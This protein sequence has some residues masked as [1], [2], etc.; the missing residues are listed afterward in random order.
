MDTAAPYG[1][2]RYGTPNR[3]NER[4]AIKIEGDA[5][6]AEAWADYINS[7]APTLD[8]LPVPLVSWRQ[9]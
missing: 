3:P 4:V 5:K 7:V 1:R 2:N 6:M 9:G 8:A